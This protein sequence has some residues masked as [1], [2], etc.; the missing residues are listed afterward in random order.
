VA[1]RGGSAGAAGDGERGIEQFWWVQSSQLFNVAFTV[2]DYEGDA[3]S[4]RG[5]RWGLS[6][7]R[8]VG[9]GIGKIGWWIGRWWTCR[10]TTRSSIP[11][12]VMTGC[13]RWRF[14]AC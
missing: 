2:A 5:D 12:G 4:G 7:G 8:W 6:G 10:S 11:V 14:G 3:G 1:V 9:S 13:L